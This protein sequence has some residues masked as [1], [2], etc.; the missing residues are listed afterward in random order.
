MQ[1]YLDLD[2]C[3]WSRQEIKELSEKKDPESVALLSTLLTTRLEFG[4]AGLRGAMGGGYCRMNELVVIQASQGL[5]QYLSQ[6]VP[7]AKEKGVVVAFDHRHNS[8]DFAQLAAAV[9]LSKGIKVYFYP[10]LA[11]T[12]LV[13]FAVVELGACAGIMVTAS[14]NPKT[15]NG[16]KVYSG[17]GC[18]IISPHD[19]AIASSILEN[20]VPWTWDKTLVST[21]NLCI[22]PTKDMH[23][24]YWKKLS[25]LSRNPSKVSSVVK[26]CYTPMH[27]VGLEFAMKA[28]ESFNLAPMTVVPQQ[29]NPDPEFPTVSFPNPEERGA[30]DLAMKHA[31][32]N[33]C[34]LIFANDPDAGTSMVLIKR[35]LCLCGMAARFKVMESFHWKSNWYFTSIICF[36]GTER[37]QSKAAL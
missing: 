31:E 33:S 20:L 4:T 17:N 5:C 16:F 12:P 15:D 9:F 18:Q 29:A 26:V 22:D 1:T 36:G 35:S 32:L 37:C 13:P 23:S 6:T 25:S 28:V 24:L 3:D 2:Q 10:S 11:F 21:S 30:L 34:Q 27:G 14:H 19:K 8:K 7:D